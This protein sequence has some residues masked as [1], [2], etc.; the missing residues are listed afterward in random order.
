MDTGKKIALWA[1]LICVIV[2]II[3][4]SISFFGID[5]LSPKEV[6]AYMIYSII[7]CV[8]SVAYLIYSR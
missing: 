6:R 7:G 8:V 5:F 1:T 4:G 2:Y 3:M